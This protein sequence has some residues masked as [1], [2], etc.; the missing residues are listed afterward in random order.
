MKLNPRV[1]T[2]DKWSST[3]G[4]WSL[5]LTAVNRNKKFLRKAYY[6]TRRAIKFYKS[7]E[8]INSIS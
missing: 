5:A 7:L 3:C 8:I 4:P 2:I 6:D 1:A